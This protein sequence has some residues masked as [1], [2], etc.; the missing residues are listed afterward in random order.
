[1]ELGRIVTNL[2]LSSERPGIERIIDWLAHSDF[3]TAPASAGHHSNYA[4]GL[5]R[6]SL[7]VYEHLRDMANPI[8]DGNLAICGLLH[9]VCKIGVY[10][11]DIEPASSAQANYLATLASRSRTKLP[12]QI[13]KNYASG[14]IQWFKAGAP[15]DMPKEQPGWVFNDPFPI[16][17]GAKSVIL[18]LSKGLE[19]TEH[20]ALAIR[21]HMGPWSNA[22]ERSYNAARECTPLVDALFIADMQATLEEKW[23]NRA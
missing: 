14:L 16:D 17:H 10:V 1:M 5:I 2:L 23:E 6:H 11:P 4:G 12:E 13:T 8:L 7:L 21:Y 18:L 15:G 20:E 19:L 3:T 9:D 22:D